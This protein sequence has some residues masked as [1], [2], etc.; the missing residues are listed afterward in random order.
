MLYPP[1]LQAHITCFQRLNG[2][3][4]YHGISRGVHMVSIT[5]QSNGLPALTGAREPL[6]QNEL[7]P[8]LQ[9]IAPIWI[10]SAFLRSADC[11][12]D[13]G[14]FPKSLP[15]QIP[16]DIRIYGISLD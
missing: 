13:F 6:W 10:D 4:E 8:L 11:I 16:G 1:E 15:D 7:I 9:T 2:S 12:A 14:P 5:Q 3:V